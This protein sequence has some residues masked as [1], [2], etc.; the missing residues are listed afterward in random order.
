ARAFDA[1]GADQKPDQAKL[2]NLANQWYSYIQ[3]TQ[4]EAEDLLQEIR[5][6]YKEMNEIK[7]QQNNNGQTGQTGQGNPN[8]NLNPRGQQ[9]PPRGGNPS[10]R[11]PPG[12][13]GGR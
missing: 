10:G 4:L 3:N 12:Y 8:P 6:Y 5:K 1:V 7:A 13:E 2:A 9:V 11:V